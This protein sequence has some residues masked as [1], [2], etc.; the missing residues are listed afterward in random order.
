MAGPV[1]PNA[2]VYAVA[3]AAAPRTVLSAATSAPGRAE[4][5]GSRAASAVKVYRYLVAMPV[6]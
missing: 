5:P 2:G 4:V 3:S 1:S 6:A